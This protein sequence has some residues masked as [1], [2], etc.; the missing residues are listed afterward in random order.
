VPKVATAE[1]D[2][3]TVYQ[4]QPIADARVNRLAQL[5]HGRLWVSDPSSFNDPFD[6]RLYIRD[7]TCRG[8][9]S[10]E[11]RLRQA[12]A[13]LLRDNSAVRDYW[14]FDAPLL[15]TLEH[16][17]AGCATSADVIAAVQRRFNSFGVACFTEEWQSPLMWS[18]YADQHAGFC[19]EYRVQKQRLSAE[20]RQVFVQQQVQYVSTLPEICLSEVLFSPHQVLC[21]LLSTKSIEW[22]YEREWRLI[23]FGQ[24]HALVDLPE[25]MEISAL[26]GGI[27]IPDAALRQLVETADR[28][29]VPAFRVEADAHYAMVLKPLQDDGGDGESQLRS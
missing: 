14:L 18:H 9:F 2:A 27:R 5:A 19:I 26:I 11:T 4:F 6:L 24:S 17:I 22:A 3:D 20:A 10:D 23:N 7:L 21:R 13:C 1:R 12:L 16:W 8:P 28:L 29:D 25:G 15:S